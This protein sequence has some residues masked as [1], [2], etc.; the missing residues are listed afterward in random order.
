MNSWLK[1]LVTVK[2]NFDQIII[3]SFSRFTYK[4][5]PSWLWRPNIFY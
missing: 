2:H 4:M 1:R 3:V 5:V